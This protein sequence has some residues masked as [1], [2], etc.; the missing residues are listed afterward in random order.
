MCP[1]RPGRVVRREGTMVEVRAGDQV[2][3]CSALAR[4]EVRTGD[5]VLTHGDRVLTILTPDEA[6]EMADAAA[7][8]APTGG[9]ADSG[10]PHP[11]GAA[12]AVRDAAKSAPGGP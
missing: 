11:P 4:P 6:S 2:R 3:W 7:G 9:T 12:R 8:R 1:S 10:P 5:W